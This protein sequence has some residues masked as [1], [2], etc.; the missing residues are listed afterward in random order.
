MILVYVRNTMIIPIDKAGIICHK[1]TIDISPYPICVDKG[2]SYDTSANKL[3]PY[4]V[5][6]MN[7][8]KKIKF[9]ILLSY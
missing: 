9:S 8:N 5:V 4:Q 3:H 1:E 7:A 2:L 6:D